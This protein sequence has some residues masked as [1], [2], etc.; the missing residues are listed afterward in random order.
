[1][2]TDRARQA[3]FT[4]DLWFNKRTSPPHFPNIITL[5]PETSLGR[6]ESARCAYAGPSVEF[7]VKDSFRSLDLTPLGFSTLLQASWLWRAPSFPEA[8]TNCLRWKRVN[9]KSELLAWETAWWPESSPAHSPYAVFNT[10]L[11]THPSVTFL[12]GFDAGALVAGAAV[13]EAADVVGLTCVFV[14][15]VTVACIR[16]ELLPVIASRFPGKAIVVYAAG[17][18][19]MEWLACGFEEVGPLSVWLRKDVT[20]AVPERRSSR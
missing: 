8:S 5:R 13:T 18:E 17:G 11:L 2:T 3:T 20:C 14:R 4:D 6:V 10:S 15:R 9:T 12:A 19:L 16:H 1:M 7:G